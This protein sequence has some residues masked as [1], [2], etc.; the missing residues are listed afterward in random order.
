MADADRFQRF[1]EEQAR[2]YDARVSFLERRFMAESRRWLGPRAS[3]DILEVGV[4]TGATLPYYPAGSQVTAVEWSPAMVAQARDKAR[5]LGIHARIEVADAMS[6]PFAD[7]C[8]DTVVATYT[9][10]CIP[11]EQ[12]ALSEAARVLRPG[13]VLLLAD[14][15]VSTSLAV[16]LGQRLLDA[17]TVPGQGEHWT[18]RPY[19]L[20]DG[21]GFD[22]VE[23]GRRTFGALEHVHAVLRT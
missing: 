8:F 9:L 14:H 16:R 17:V 10:C 4:G 11:D 23:S 21:L 19:D 20:L 1:W 2:T 3:G 13:G 12:V 5:R 22:V 18:R 15:V 6:L 7:D